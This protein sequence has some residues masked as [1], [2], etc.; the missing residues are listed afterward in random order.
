MKLSESVVLYKNR[1]FAICSASANGMEQ[2]GTMV[3][4][5]LAIKL[6]LPIR[7]LQY[8]RVSFPSDTSNKKH[9]RVTGLVRCTLQTIS[10]GRPD[11]SV[12]FLARVVRDLHQLT[13]CEA[14]ADTKL[15]AKLKPDSKMKEDS[16][17]TR[18]LKEE[19]G[20]EREIVPYTPTVYWWDVL[21]SDPDTF[22][23]AAGKTL[24]DSDPDDLA[25]SDTDL[26]PVNIDGYDSDNSIRSGDCICDCRAA[27]QAQRE[28]TGRIYLSSSSSARCSCDDDSCGSTDDS[29]R[30]ADL[31][32]RQE[33]G[34]TY[35]DSSSSCNS[36][37]IR[38]VRGRNK[39]DSPS[40]KAL[41]KITKEDLD[42]EEARRDEWHKNRGVWHN[43][44]LQKHFP[45]G[46]ENAH[47]LG[48]L[49]TRE[50]KRKEED[51]RRRKEET[52]KKEE[53]A[54][55]KGFKKER[56]LRQLY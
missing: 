16:K 44:V 3:D 37:H 38:K 32:G 18:E 54:K 43:I 55:Q 52:R 10:K 39:K 41:A 2:F 4:E 7:Q 36:A 45:G 46:A 51:A 34:Q 14:L 5:S 30:A 8:V 15:M 20:K 53:D 11:R 24:S 47:R 19:L 27:R 50:K 40:A 21:G 29:R 26:R 25:K 23:T 17:E 1:P 12:A 49:L 13:Q 48:V 9:T 31:A 33:T 6:Q 42:A 35:L 56:K 28:E 22:G